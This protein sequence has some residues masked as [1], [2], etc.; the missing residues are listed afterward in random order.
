M[1]FYL[2][3]LAYCGLEL[4]WRGWTH[5]SMFVLGGLCFLLIGHLGRVARPLPVL[6]RAVVAAGVVTMAELACGLIVNR[7]HQ[8]WDYRHLPL[9]LGGQ[10]CLLFT[11]LWA[12]VSLA[13]IWM[14]DRAEKMLVDISR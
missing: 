13:A 11:G 14:Y 10:V 12:V 2:G 8:I 3:G 1:L 6:P 4:C 7:E 5:G 9:D